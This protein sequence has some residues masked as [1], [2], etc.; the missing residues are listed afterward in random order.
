MNKHSRKNKNNKEK[1]DYY[2]ERKIYKYIKLATK[3][4]GIHVR[5]NILIEQ[6]NQYPSGNLDYEKG[7]I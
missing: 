1:Q 7:G 4:Y 2:Y 5:V 6:K 3:K